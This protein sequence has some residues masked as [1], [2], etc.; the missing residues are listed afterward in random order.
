MSSHFSGVRLYA[1]LWTVACQAPLFMGFSRQEYWSRLPFPSPGDLPDQGMEPIS[2]CNRR[3]IL[4]S[5]NHLKSP[6]VNGKCGYSNT[7]MLVVCIHKYTIEKA[8]FCGLDVLLKWPC[9]SK[10]Y[11][12][13]M[14]GNSLMHFFSH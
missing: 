6:K 4:Y 3:Q 10:L 12:I 8:K 1:A 14:K 9:D 5:L 2:A 13:K 11:F 7:N